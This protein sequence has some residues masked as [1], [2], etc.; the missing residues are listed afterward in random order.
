MPLLLRIKYRNLTAK[1]CGKK[2]DQI[3]NIFSD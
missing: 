2:N 1:G 3:I